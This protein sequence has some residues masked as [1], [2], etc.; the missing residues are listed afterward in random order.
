M[1]TNAPVLT[2]VANGNILPAR[3]ISVDATLD[4]GCLQSGAG[5]K[6]VG[7]GQ[8]G[9]GTPPGVAGSSAYAATAGK[10]IA[11]Y[12]IGQP[13]Y[14]TAGGVVTRGDL[15]KADTNGK[16]VAGVSANDYYGAIA[17]ESGVDDA[18]IRVQVLVG[19]KTN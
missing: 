11:V 1:S 19:Q 15:L 7:V 9:I 6:V 17:L 4:F 12:G 3:F 16:G 14:L 8:L 18:L 10:A 5:S 13:C 2:F